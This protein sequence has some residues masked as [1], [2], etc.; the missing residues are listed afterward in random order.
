[1]SKTPFLSVYRVGLA[2]IW[3]RFPVVVALFLAFGW[4]LALF[5]PPNSVG[6][7]AALSAAIIGLIA[8]LRFPPCPRCGLN[9]F[10]TL[11]DKR[12]FFSGSYFFSVMHRHYYRPNGVCSR[13][14]LNLR[15]FTL[16]DPRAKRGT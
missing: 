7:V 13:C 8:D 5:L 16:F 11:R 3:L 2:W 9:V 1:M 6:I 12:R 15:H 4:G 10:V 14:G